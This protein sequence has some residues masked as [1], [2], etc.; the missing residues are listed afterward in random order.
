MTISRP[1]GFLLSAAFLAGAVPGAWA[2]TGLTGAPVLN[3]P[4]GARSSGMGRAFTGVPGDAESIMYNP[5]GL[6]F[7]PGLKAY[8]S[9]MNGF[10]GGGYGF[11]ALPVKIN[12]LTLTP[13]FLYFNSGDLDLNLSDGTTGTVVGEMDKVAM[14]SGAYMPLPGLGLGVTVK[15]TSIDLAGTASAAAMHYDLGALYALDNGL[16]FGVSSLNNGGAMKFEAKGDPAPA[17]LRAGFS[18]KH[19]FTPANYLDSSSA[20]TYCDLVFASD[21]SKVTK[22][23]G[24]YQSGV[25]MNMK[26]PDSIFLSLRAGFLFGRPE[27]GLTFG[28]GIKNGPWDFGFAF[29][30]AKALDS[31]RPVS[32]SYQF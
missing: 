17:A 16:S 2:G 14:L 26:M 27:E 12:N 29:E 30:T 21:W 23:K 13:A 9:Y 31:R 6:A 19:T 15:R 32:L 11:G 24:F 22:E 20:I 28:I 25:E 5:A 1:L 4:V 7:A 3:R 18:Y 8:A 10:D